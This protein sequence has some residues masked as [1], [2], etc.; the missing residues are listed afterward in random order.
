[1]TKSNN[2]IKILYLL[3]EQGSQGGMTA[4]TKMYY[5]IGLFD[6]PDIKHFNTSYRHDSRLL[7]LFES[8]STKIKYIITLLTFKPDAIYV[9]T[10]SSWGFYDKC[11]YC[12]IAK[13]F[14][15][16]SIINPVGGA[17]SHYYENSRIHRSLIDFFIKVP[18][19][20]IAGSTYWY[21]YFI[22]QFPDIQVEKVPNPIN[23]QEFSIK[24][25]LRNDN[26]FRI[27]TV[28]NI[29]K[30]KG[31]VELS[32]VIDI[33]CKN[34]NNVD[35]VVMGEGEMRPVMERELG[36]WIEKNRLLITGFVSEAKKIEWLNK[37]DLFILLSHFEVLPISILEAMSSSLPVVATYTGG[38]PDVVKNG[39]NGKLTKVKDSSEAIEAVSE[40]VIMNSSDLINM[41]RNS[42]NIVENNYDVSKIAEKHKYLL[43]MLVNNNL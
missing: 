15:V 24:R 29:I 26:R 10:S 6:D 12:L 23:V 21:D 1:M 19:L 31:I 36:Q 9:M 2:K 40:F 43:G 3:P 5:E 35:F 16:K 28:S 25:E 4:I 41:G 32:Q 22:K 14:S 39:I 33:I 7:R 30:S 20:L 42:F 34:Y 17:F 18:D 38:I 8:I 37:S 13:L 27:V 11:I